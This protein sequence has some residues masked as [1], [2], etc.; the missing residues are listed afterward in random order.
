MDQEN[1]VEILICRT[2]SRDLRIKD[3]LKTC[4]YKNKYDILIVGYSDS[5]LM[6]PFAGLISAK[7]IWDAF[8]SL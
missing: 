2:I 3:H 1:G 7:I 6:V 4:R 8:I 5:R